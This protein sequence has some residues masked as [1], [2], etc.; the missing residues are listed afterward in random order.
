MGTGPLTGKPEDGVE[1]IADENVQVLPAEQSQTGGREAVEIEDVD[2]VEMREALAEAGAEKPDGLSQPEHEDADPKPNDTAAAAEPGKSAEET[3]P[4][5]PVLIAKPRFDEVLDRAK[6]GERAA[7]ELAA[8][9]IRLKQQLEQHTG[10]AVNPE[11]GALDA[12]IDE[13]AQKFDDGTITYKDMKA[14]ERVIQSRRDQI[15]EQEIV[16]RATAR[17]VETAPKAPNG[18]DG[19]LDDQT[20]QVQQNYGAYIDAI[21]LHMWDSTVEHVRASL[22]ASGVKLDGS[23]KATATIRQKIGEYAK[24]EHHFFARAS[25]IEPVKPS[26]QQQARPTPGNQPTPEQ[27]R[28]KLALQADMA[29][30]LSTMQRGTGS[31]QMLTEA[32]IEEMDEEA[33]AALPAATRNRLLGLS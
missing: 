28:A 4:S 11:L 24:Q 7:A 3:R 13:L 32:Q 17:A 12:Q 29:P 10:P 23:A 30:D 19:W 8:E 6:K 1:I 5:G 31:D 14:Q 16:N 27:R 15:R 22:I 18:N 21:P 26:G 33:I 20:Q 25:G 9:N 2:A